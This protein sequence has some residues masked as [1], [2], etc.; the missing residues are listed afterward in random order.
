MSRVES[1]SVQRPINAPQILLN[2]QQLV[3][4][5]YDI[6]SYT[7]ESKNQHCCIYI[8]SPAYY[9]LIDSG[10]VGREVAGGV[11]IVLAL[12]LVSLSAFLDSM[13]FVRARE[14]VFGEATTKS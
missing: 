1:S 5:P 8:C 4:Q 7:S 2:P 3:G 6:Y 10:L 11:M 12:D 13:E 9:T 14:R